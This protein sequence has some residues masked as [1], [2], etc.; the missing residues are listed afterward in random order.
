M[1][2]IA[3]III[4]KIF[5]WLFSGHILLSP[6]QIFLISRNIIEWWQI[7]F[8]CLLVLLYLFITHKI[9]KFFWWWSKRW[10]INKTHVITYVFMFWVWLIIRILFIH[11]SSSD[12]EENANIWAWK[13]AKI[14]EFKE[15]KWYILNFTNQ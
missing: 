8:Y 12:I 10:W 3:I 1:L 6:E 2:N 13:I 14:I 15:W 4:E 5:D 9:C 7:L 11:P